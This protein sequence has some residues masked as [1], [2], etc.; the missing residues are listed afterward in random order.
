MCAASFDKAL[1]PDSNPQKYKG[2]L[3]GK[4]QTLLQLSKGL[5]YIHSQKLVH[6]DIKPH[7]VLISG[8]RPA[9]VKWGDFGLS[10]PIHTDGAYT[11]SGIIGT[12]TYMAPEVLKA[13]P[14]SKATA[15]SDVF[16]AGCLFFEILTDGEHPFG[17]KQDSHAIIDSNIMEDSPTNIESNL[18]YKITIEQSLQLIISFSV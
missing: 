12:K 15:Q 4:F 14:G 3:P 8:T 1:L 9:K 7:N 5:Q 11:L 6:R 2:D 16:S 10:K 18:C 17:S 13:S